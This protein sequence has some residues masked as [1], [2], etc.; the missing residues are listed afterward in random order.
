VRDLEDV[1][2]DVVYRLLYVVRGRRHEDV[3]HEDAEF[4]VWR[5][6]CAV[7]RPSVLVVSEPVLELVLGT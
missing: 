5:G 2:E 1:A 3:L 6:L 7:L 4:E